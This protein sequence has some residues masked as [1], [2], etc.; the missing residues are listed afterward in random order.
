MK[1]P[2]TRAGKGKR[3][4]RKIDTKYFALPMNEP[5]ANRTGGRIGGKPNGV[6]SGGR[7]PTLGQK[8]MR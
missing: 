4:L 1:I 7:A 5:T 3:T 6:G 2:R 8:R